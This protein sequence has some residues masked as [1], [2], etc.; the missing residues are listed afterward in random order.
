M[1]PEAYDPE[2]SGA[3]VR[4]GLPGPGPL[5]LYCSSTLPATP[6]NSALTAGQAQ[7]WA[8]GLATYLNNMLL[9]THKKKKKNG[10]K[11]RHCG[12]DVR[13]DPDITGYCVGKPAAP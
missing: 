10:E 11:L 1:L 6:A 2:G 7:P 4:H 8:A 3:V 5:G 9:S 12:V 13:H